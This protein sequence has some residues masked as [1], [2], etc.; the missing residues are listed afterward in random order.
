[1][2]KTYTPLK[3]RSC[4]LLR[5]LGLLRSCYA[6]AARR[7]VAQKQERRRLERFE[8]LLFR[9]RT[10]FYF[11]AVYPSFPHLFVCS[12]YLRMGWEILTFPIAEPDR[13]G[14]LF[15]L[16]GIKTSRFPQESR[17][18]WSSKISR[19][20][21]RGS[22]D[23]GNPEITRVPSPETVR[24]RCQLERVNVWVLSES[25]N[26]A[27]NYAKFSAAKIQPQKFQSHKFQHANINQRW[28]CITIV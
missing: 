18:C 17:A 16:S 5:R 24:I 11:V 20:P 7:I 28:I 2:L 1:M 10:W 25:H 23:R 12:L 21:R 27:G 4:Y 3:L 13:D 8:A 22:W 19:V 6:L 9:V 26:F 15:S 14:T